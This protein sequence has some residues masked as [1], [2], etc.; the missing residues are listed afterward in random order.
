MGVSADPLAPALCYLFNPPNPNSQSIFQIKLNINAMPSPFL[1]LVLAFLSLIIC[2]EASK[3]I[4]LDT[5]YSMSYILITQLS[6]YLTVNSNLESNF[7][8]R[9]NEPIPYARPTPATGNR[10]LI[11]DL[12]RLNKRSQSEKSAKIPHKRQRSI[13]NQNFLVIFSSNTQISL[14]KS[15][16]ASYNNYG[17]AKLRR[18]IK[19]DYI[20]E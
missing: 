19:K 3:Y 14:P 2:Y 11:N 4:S 12:T 13:V 8:S 10:F 7:C 5:K 9:I 18:R 1:L 20:E 16:P 17:A 15:L 6:P